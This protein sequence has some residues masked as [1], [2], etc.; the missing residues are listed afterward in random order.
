MLALHTHTQTHT[1]PQE[2]KEKQAAYEESEALIE[3][4]NRSHGIVVSRDKTAGHHG[5]CT[6]VFANLILFL[7]V[8]LFALLV[9]FLMI[10]SGSTHE[11]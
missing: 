8:A 3:L 11:H 9:R 2:I 1:H 5:Y 7:C 4:R 6:G 10:T